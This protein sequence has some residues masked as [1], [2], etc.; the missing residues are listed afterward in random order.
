[1]NTRPELYDAE[2]GGYQ[3]IPDKRADKHFKEPVYG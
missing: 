3:V 2:I 1:M